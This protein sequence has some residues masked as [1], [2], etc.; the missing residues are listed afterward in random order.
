MLY[1]IWRRL[2]RVFAQCPVCRCHRYKTIKEGLKSH[3]KS[4]MGKAMDTL[5]KSLNWIE[6]TRT[7]IISLLQYGKAVDMYLESWYILPSYLNPFR[8]LY[9]VNLAGR[10]LSVWKAQCIHL[11]KVL[12][13]PWKRMEITYGEIC[14]KQLI[15][16]SF[17]VGPKI[18]TNK[19]GV[20]LLSAFKIDYIATTCMAPGN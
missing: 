1:N 18:S 3:D 13:P 11:F 14:A 12:L 19:M 5:C 4:L 2:L 20:L 15:F 6:T 9:K 8:I 7:K 10:F 17:F 16:N